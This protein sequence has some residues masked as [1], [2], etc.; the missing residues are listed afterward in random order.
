MGRYVHDV[1]Y[2]ELNKVSHTLL[3]DILLSYLKKYDAVIV[4]IRQVQIW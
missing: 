2:S 1:I 4:T 3:H